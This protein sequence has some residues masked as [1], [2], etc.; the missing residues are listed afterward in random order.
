MAM[1]EQ[2]DGPKHRNKTN[3]SKP[4]VQMEV[5][6][7]KKKCPNAA[8]RAPMLARQNRDVDPASRQN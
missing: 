2:A 4:M 3:K 8:S 6:S 7:E 5:Q 1:I